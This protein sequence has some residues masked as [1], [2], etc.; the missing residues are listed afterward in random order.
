[1]A[2]AESHSDREFVE[3]MI[4]TDGVEAAVD[5][6]LARQE[7]ELTRLASVLDEACGTEFGTDS[8]AWRS[9]MQT[10]YDKGILGFGRSPSDTDLPADSDLLGRLISIGAEV[11]SGEPD[12]AVSQTR[13]LPPKEDEQ[14]PVTPVAQESSPPGHPVGLPHF[15]RQY[16]ILGKLGEGGMGT[17]YKAT[18]VAMDRT[19]ALKV[20]A[21]WLAN[22]QDYV[23]RFLKEAKFAARLDHPN[24]VRAIDAGS[25]AGSY[26]IAMEYIEGE[27]LGQLLKRDRRID[28]S[29]A[30]RIAVQVAHGLAHAQEHGL[31]HR[32]VK[33][34]NIM[35][36]G[37]GTAKLADLG[38]AKTT[39]PDASHVTQTGV[40]LGT[41][42]YMSPEQVRAD[43]N[44]DIRSDIYSLGATLYRALT[45]RP[46]FDGTT[47]FMVAHKHLNEDPVPATE[48]NPEVSKHAEAVISKMMAKQPADRYDSPSQLIED[49]ECVLGGERPTYALG[50]RTDEAGSTTAPPVSSTTT[51]VSEHERRGIHWRYA[52]PSLAGLVI[53]VAVA[54]WLMGDRSPEGS[55]ESR[56]PTPSVAGGSK[57]PPSTTVTDLVEPRLAAEKSLVSVKRLPDEAAITPVADRL[58]RA[59]DSAEEARAQGKF[60]DA[61]TSY[62]AIR[63]QAASL[64]EQ[65][66]DIDAC[67]RESAS[68]SAKRARS[69]PVK[70][71]AS[72]EWDIA[73]TA[74]Q[75]G[76]TSRTGGRFAKAARDF[77][78]ASASYDRHYEGA[79]PLAL[80]GALSKARSAEQRNDAA[81]A[82]AAYEA[83]REYG[84]VP[85]ANIT[86]LKE[87]LERSSAVVEARK[88]V[89][90]GRL[91][92]ASQAVLTMAQRWPDAAEVSALDELVRRRMREEPPVALS[93]GDGVT[94]PFVAIPA[95]TFTMGAN[96][97]RRDERPQHTVVIS[98][99]FRLSTTEITQDQYQS[100]M[101]DNPS[102]WRGPAM[103][104]HNVSWDDATEFC[105]R[106]STKLGKRIRLPTEA[107]WEYACRLGAAAGDE[108]TEEVAWCS[109]NSDR[110]THAAATKPADALRLHDMLGNVWEW[111]FDVYAADYYAHSAGTDPTGPT[112]GETRVLRGGSWMSRPASCRP[113]QRI[114]Y[115]PDVRYSDVGFRVV[116]DD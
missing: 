52:T 107:E 81:S 87:L 65:T 20:L 74:Y 37:D 94:L 116:C 29:R 73:E 55:G 72:S 57:A 110:Q 85:E 14:T 68:A 112:K 114:H 35:L 97:G 92:S 30:L 42:L 13:R 101:G 49:L 90:D 108:A 38:L 77:V 39:D 104:V 44:I 1:M 17:V 83:A 103:P 34:E 4:D 2:G 93:L 63:K 41:P 16:E 40:S 106:A 105:R 76:V 56:S 99:S 54:T 111:C 109:T 8:V 96:S 15:P 28:E 88:L 64:V 78:A 62:L 9:W 22:N 5:Y 48:R 115:P 43:R 53:L 75:A 3:R 26:Y 86:Q 24:V 21:P 102:N 67:R 61:L 59:W 50:P 98:R 91:G 51:S 80:A 69:E 33:P 36:A 79:A 11:G 45:G 71:L 46:P 70:H 12:L 84:E 6:V 89:D 19:V 31:V 66:K 32:D 100:V 25:E 47:A 60:D 95:G 10:L 23:A 113:E 82:L 58:R 7:P 27:T 18:Q